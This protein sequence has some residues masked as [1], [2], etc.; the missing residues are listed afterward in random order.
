MTTRAV[1]VVGGPGT[2]KT[3]LVRAL[4][5][6]LGLSQDEA[7]HVCPHLWMTPLRAP[8][9]PDLRGW[10]W[11]R[12]RG[13]YSGTDALSIHQA[14]PWGLKW[15]AAETE[16]GT[17][18]PV[19]IGEGMRLSS[20]R[21]L[22]A[23]DRIINGGLTIVRLTASEAAAADRLTARD[24]T[25]RERFVKSALTRASRAAE[26]LGALGLPVLEFSTDLLG[27]EE[28]AAEI[29]EQVVGSSCWKERNR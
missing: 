12:E 13:V 7:Q 16:A 29:L 18:P 23:Y 5:A 20:P 9:G 22:V 27:P 2:G 4:V 11:G 26:T 19:M 14:Q 10:V 15:L 3:T 21:F 6:A 28:I 25:V 8:E 24:G 17:L 1:Y